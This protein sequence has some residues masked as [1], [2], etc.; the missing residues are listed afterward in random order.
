MKAQAD[1]KVTLEL[2]HHKRPQQN[3]YYDL[4]LSNTNVDFV[5]LGKNL[6]LSY[7]WGRGL[8][9][10][11]RV[12]EALLYSQESKANLIRFILTS[13]RPTG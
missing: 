13:K 2:H 10:K 11:G 7:V 1:S 3:W 12:G 5:L 4:K 8:S 6:C 9:E